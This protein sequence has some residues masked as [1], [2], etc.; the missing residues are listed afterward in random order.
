MALIQRVISKEDFERILEAPEKLRHKV[1]L[2]ILYALG[3]RTGELRLICKN[4]VDLKNKTIRIFDSKKKRYFTLPIDTKTRDLIAEYIQDV[5]ILE[6]LF[7]SSHNKGYPVSDRAIEM[8]V[9]KYA[10]YVLDLPV[11]FSPRWFRYRFARNW[12]VKK[13]SLTGLQNMLRH[14]KISSTAIYIDSI[15]F[16][17]EVRDEYDEIME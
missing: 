13:G 15:R 6:Y 5:E 8:L 12:I 9:K 11:E 14:K 3:L 7:E 2:R 10:C 17:D 16:Q 1:L 4:D